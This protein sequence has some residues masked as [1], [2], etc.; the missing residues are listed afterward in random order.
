[1]PFD[2]NTLTQLVEKLHSG[3]LSGDELQQLNEWRA[4]S[5]QNEAAIAELADPVHVQNEL[6]SVHKFTINAEAVLSNILQYKQVTASPF[7]WKWIAVPALII[8]VAGVGYWQYLSRQ[9]DNAAHAQQ[10]DNSKM[11]PGKNGVTLTLSTGKVIDI[12]NTNLGLITTDASS[13]IEKAKDGALTY[14]V[15]NCICIEGKNAIST[16]AEKSFSLVLQDGTK[17]FLNSLSRLEFATHFTGSSKRIVEVSGE[18]YF[19]VVKDNLRPF[20]V[21]VK[22][23]QLI[24]ASN[25]FQVRAYENEISIKSMEA[26][27]IIIVN[28]GM[29]ILK[30]GQTL[31]RDSVTVK[32][33]IGAPDAEAKAAWKI[34]TDIKEIQKAFRK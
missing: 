20:H 5:P 9:K 7:P 19:E 33:E 1:M 17:V 8:I 6:Q 4:A 23:I 32:W 26:D 2:I 34:T 18:A 24:V 31:K 22:N 16:P 10:A 27:D 14:K 11:P 25:K 3:S 15:V 21:K 13:R 30:P 29:S 28:D 12:G